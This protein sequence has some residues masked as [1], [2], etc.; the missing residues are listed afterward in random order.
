MKTIF[1]LFLNKKRKLS[2]HKKDL[3]MFLKKCREKMEKVVYSKSLFLKRLK[4]ILK[5]KKSR[6]EKDKKDF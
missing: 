4:T 6:K 5:S 3:K 2:P 1:V